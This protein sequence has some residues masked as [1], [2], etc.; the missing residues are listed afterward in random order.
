MLGNCQIVTYDAVDQDL[1]MDS[2]FNSVFLISLTFILAGFVKGVAGMGLPTVAMG[3]L[4]LLMAPAEAAALLIVPSLITNVW[5]FAAGPHRL[6]ILRR[7]WTMLLAISVTTWAGAGLLTGTSTTTATAC[8]GISLVAY[9]IVGLTKLRFSVP[10]RGEPFLSPVVGATTGLVTGATGV[11]V[12]PAVPY[13]Q[14]LGLE[15]EDLVQALGLSFTVSTVALAAGLASH[16]SFDV[17]A[18]GASILYTIPAIAGMLIGQWIRLQ[19][20]PEAFRLLFFVG[21]LCLGGDLVL[22][23]IF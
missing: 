2:I 6:R 8:L 7:I 11:F 19:I 17:A 5:Q 20:S 4:G 10:E 22:R 9:A 3:T 13:L 18:A 16:A 12:L 21:L 1:G 23:T 14:A 15:K